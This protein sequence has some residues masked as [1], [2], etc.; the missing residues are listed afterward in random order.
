MCRVDVDIAKMLLSKEDYTILFLTV[1]KLAENYRVPCNHKAF[2][3]LINQGV[4][5]GVTTVFDR[6]PV[7][8]EIR[9]AKVRG[10]R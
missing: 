2:V 3:V 10:L 4:L 7:I 9:L 6:L 8:S 5:V 1:A